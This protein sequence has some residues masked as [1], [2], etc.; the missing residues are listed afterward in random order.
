MSKLLL[1]QMNNEGTVRF[2]SEGKSVPIMLLYLHR[3][4]LED[5]SHN[6][7]FFKNCDIYVSFLK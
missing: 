2:K 1:E 6:N 4:S 3:C 7:N 5:I